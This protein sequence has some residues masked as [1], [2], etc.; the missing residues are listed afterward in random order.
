MLLAEQKSAGQN[1]EKA[2]DQALDYVDSLAD[3]E[4]PRLIVVSDFANMHV[5][6]LED[7]EDVAE[8][9]L[10]NLPN[11]IDRFLFLAGYTTRRFEEEDAVNVQA[12]ELL[13]NVYLELEKDGYVGEKLGAFIVRILFL[14][15]GDSTGLWPRQ[16]WGDFLRNRT[17]EDGSDLGMWLGRLFRVLNQPES[18]RSHNLDE[19]LAAFPYV[20]GGLFETNFEPPDTNRDMREHLLR[21]THFDWSRISPAI[22]GSMFQSVMNHDE[23]RSLGAHYTTE[24]NIM[25]VIS[26]LF[27]DDLKSEFEAC[28]NSAAK[29]RNFHAKLRSLTFFD[30]ACGCGNFLVIAYRELRQLEIALLHRLHGETVQQTLDLEAWRKIDVDQFF[31]IEIVEFPARI[32]E[33]VLSVSLVE[34]Q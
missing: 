32:A 16:A 21:A 26:A 27:L 33:T 13:G 25:K 15:F 5:L 24:R 19:D 10:A 17:S 8:F 18:K 6:D 1:L 34:H 12:A 23:R 9:P 31:G 22:F 30:P 11:E 29:L 7:P 3:T 20:N 14:L 2:M 28:G 4:L